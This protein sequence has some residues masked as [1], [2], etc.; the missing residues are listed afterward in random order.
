MGN[1]EDE[2]M[3]RLCEE[4]RIMADEVRLW[5]GLLALA[6][7]AFLAAPALGEEAAVGEGGGGYLPLGDGWE[8]GELSITVTQG[9]SIPLI[10]GKNNVNS[11]AVYATITTEDAWSLTV[12]DQDTTVTKGRMTEYIID[13]GAYVDTDPDQL[14]AVMSVNATG[15]Y[16]SGINCELPNGGQIA[17]GESQVTGVQIPINFIQPVSWD[18]PVSESGR[19]YKIVVTF[20]IS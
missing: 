14:D 17:R 1:L 13:G 5:R 8:T 10:P 4:M 3:R 11:T 9:V 15:T 18:D 6:L 2:G 12:S 16:S 7:L 20:T 19:G